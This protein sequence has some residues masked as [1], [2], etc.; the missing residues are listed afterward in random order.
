MKLYIAFVVLYLAVGAGIL[1]TKGDA[2]LPTDRI[3]FGVI[4]FLV[5]VVGMVLLIRELS[6]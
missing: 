3:M 5:A 6:P 1:M 4:R 2:L